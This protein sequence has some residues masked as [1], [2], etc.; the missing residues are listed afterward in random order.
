MSL[1]SEMK[2]E[3]V[4]IIGA[5][6]AGISC[7]IQLKRYGIEPLIFEKNE[8]GGMLRYANL[9]ENYPGFPNGIT[10]IDLVGLFKK[11]I[12]KN[13]INICSE[14]VISVKYSEQLFFIET[15]GD[16]FNSKVLVIASGTKPNKKTGVVVPSGLEKNVLYDITL[17]MGCSGK[18]IVIAGAG[19]LAIDYSMTLGRKND[20]TV[21]N[22]SDKIKCI[23]ALL[24]RIESLINFRY[25]EKTFVKN[26]MPQSPDGINIECESKGKP[27]TLTAEY[28]IFSIGR[29]PQLDFIGEEFNEISDELEFNGKLFRIGDVNNLYFRQTAI[30][31]GDGIKTAMQI[32][33]ILK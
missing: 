19:D 15:A 12:E 7:A 31:A 26:I 6:P 21:I 27:L 16:V 13:N 3:D 10:G 11:H 25:I 28:L 1:K 17:V 18:K 2:V 5:G 32:N 8:T 33:D 14:N 20:V 4:I 22:R 9:V 30:A 29:L 24:K 23:P